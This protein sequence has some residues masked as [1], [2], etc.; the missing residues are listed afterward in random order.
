MRG[1]VASSVLCVSAFACAGPPAPDAA[2]CRDVITRLCVA[3]VCGRA[4]TALSVGAEGC[5]A[6]LL[7]RTGC[8]DDDFA[9]TTPTR[10][11]FVECR[12]PLV[13]AT[14]TTGVKAPCEDV[15]RFLSGCADVQ[16]FLKG[17]SS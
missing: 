14:T 4:V 3:P 17:G 2:L 16:A 9:F 11:R 6:T 5:E 13:S 7:G 12:E 10:A 15:D 1:L 8:D